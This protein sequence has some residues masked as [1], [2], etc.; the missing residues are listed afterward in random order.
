MG[1]LDFLPT[2]FAFCGFLGSVCGHRNFGCP[3]CPFGSPLFRVT[4]HL[5]LLAPPHF[6]F[7]LGASRV[8]ALAR[9]VPNDGA[10]FFCGHLPAQK[11]ILQQRWLPYF[12]TPAVAQFLHQHR[13]KGKWD[14]HNTHIPCFG[15]ALGGFWY[16]LVF[17]SAPALPLCLR[18]QFERGG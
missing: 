1:L 9:S 16:S 8:G 12:F 2:W 5:C 7:I 6:L 18:P 4:Y 13:G 10:I 14:D 11:G 17:G 3:H 15:L